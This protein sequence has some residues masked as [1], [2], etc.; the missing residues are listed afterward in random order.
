M[1]KEVG[2]LSDLGL[3]NIKSIGV[4]RGEKKTKG[5]ENAKI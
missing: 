1:R 5:K 4:R 3:T 2:A